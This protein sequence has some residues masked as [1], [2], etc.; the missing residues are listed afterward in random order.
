MKWLIIEAPGKIQ[1][2]AKSA[3]KAWPGEEIRVLATGGT[4]RDIPTSR[5][6]VN[7][8]TFRLEGEVDLQNAARFRGS[9]DKTIGEYGRANK[10]DFEIWVMSDPDREGEA[11]ATQVWEILKEYHLAAYAVR[12]YVTDLSPD[13]LQSAVISQEPDPGMVS[14]RIARRALDRLIPR[15]LAHMAGQEDWSGLGRVQMAAL[16]V[17]QSRV[18]SW[19]KYH[20][21]GN[22][23]KEP[24]WRINQKFVTH[25]D[26]ERA[27][28]LAKS[29][30]APVVTEVKTVRINPPPPHNAATLLAA[31]DTL[32]PEDVSK[33]AQE[34]YISGR[35]SYPR[36]DQSNLTTAARQSV[37][38]IAS[39]FHASSRLREG[40]YNEDDTGA[41]SSDMFSQGAHPGLHP[42]LLILEPRPPGYS[43]EADVVEMEICARAMAHLMEPALIRRS[44]AWIGEGEQRVMVVK[45][46][47]IEPGWTTA[48]E[49][50]DLN[51]PLEPKPG[52]ERSL[53]LDER[54]P[55]PRDVVKWLH[56]EGLGRPSTLAY[57][58]RKMQ[59]NGLVSPM[60][61]LTRKG[62][63]RLDEVRRVAQGVT[64]PQ[65][66]RDLEAALEKLVD[67][68]RQYSQ[69]LAR[70][71][72]AAGLDIT[73]LFEMQESVEVAGSDE[74]HGKTKVGVV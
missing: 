22:P 66:T 17:I 74:G 51:N 58:P 70:L 24:G 53:R 30:G 1:S 14:A 6:G 13:G 63:E 20:L 68:P 33:A 65:Y 15:S 34:A 54:Y 26:A 56:D 52:T 23:F 69:T 9:L 44:I 48:Y 11:I 49:R 18:A 3:R 67:N 16:H 19:R 7:L 61:H 31:V 45:N 71:I 27:L 10:D 8:Q 42:T 73:R 32:H 39:S 60:C 62:G 47:L 21:E 64:L 50:M 55:T 25:A 72:S 57:I 29:C 43:Q 35:V 4:L 41:G 2:L 5:L 40:W 38:Y 36:T 28:T 37:G 12:A 46:E 59:Y